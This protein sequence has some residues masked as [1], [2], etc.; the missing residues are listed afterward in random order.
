MTTS[1]DKTTHDTPL[2][3]VMC[4]SRI[5]TILLVALV[6]TPLCLGLWAQTTP[7]RSKPT[8]KQ[9]PTHVKIAPQIPNADRT[10]GNRI[11][12]EHADELNKLS[13]DSFMVL[14]GNVKFSK[15]A[16]L[17]FCD[18]AHYY[19][20]SESMDAFGNVV[21]QQGDTLFIYADELN[22]RG[23]AHEVAYLYGYDGNNVRMI[24]RDVKLETEIFTYDLTQGYGYYTTGGVLTDP[25]NHLVSD[26]G[27]YT[28]ALKEAN[29]YNNVHLKRTD[30]KDTLDIFT[31]TLNYNTVTHVAEFYSPTQIINARGIINSNAGVYNTLNN[32][33]ELFSRSTIEIDRGP[34]RKKSTFT[35]DT[36]FYDRDGGFGQAFGRVL[37][38]DSIREA[39]LSGDY[40]YYDQLLDSAFFTGNAL[41]KEYSQGDTLYIHGRYIKSLRQIDTIT[42][43]PP[44]PP[45]T[46]T[47]T[48]T[49][50]NDTATNS[51]APQPLTRIDTTHTVSAWPRVRFYRIDVQGL[52]DSMTF[53]QRD[54]ML[55]MHRHPIIWSDDRQIFGNLITL[56][57]NDSTIDHALL[58]DFGFTAQHIED[59]YYNQLTGKRMEAW[60]DNGELSRLDVSNSV[61]AIF[62]PEENDSTINKFV[63]LQTA[64]LT[65]W[66]EKRAMKRMKCWS[67]TSGQTTPIYLAKK[68]MLRLAKFQWYDNLRPTSPQ[69]VFDVSDAM[70]ELMENTPIPV[71]TLPGAP[72][73]RLQKVSR[74][75]SPTFTTGQQDGDASPGDSDTDT[76]RPD[77]IQQVQP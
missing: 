67:E 68:S 42:I 21:M 45:Q 65:G 44:T 3:R 73:M 77:T 60:F 50:G 14:T 70:N 69:S 41:A 5:S 37:L 28:P 76:P 13:T 8:A 54:S 29:F 10:N 48:D 18:S 12:L 31:D 20:E 39:Q 22:F 27:E 74:P 40:G 1:T 11:F 55:Y 75:P 2:K 51:I 15:G 71:I 56:H 63:N 26:E 57:L 62:Y 7:T 61:E 4:R 17:M 34:G 66:F 38:V 33:T 9:A 52:C 19:P 43:T 46:D 53:V 16:M 24:N 35:G 64:N 59:D 32:Q 47:F 23:G 49:L 58:P 6:L 25:L 72:D 36:I 30:G